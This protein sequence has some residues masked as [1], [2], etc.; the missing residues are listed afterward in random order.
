LPTT[1]RAHRRTKDG[2]S[3]DLV[4]AT[5]PHWI[6]EDEVLVEIHAVSLYFRDIAM[7]ARRSLPDASH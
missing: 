3:I 7:L 1:S 5:L 2:K 6:G 4:T